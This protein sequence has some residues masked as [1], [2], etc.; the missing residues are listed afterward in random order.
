MKV[1]KPEVT[2]E[3]LENVY[4]GFLE[5]FSDLGA[6]PPVTVDAVV[7]EMREKGKS[8]VLRDRGVARNLLRGTKQGVWGTE[9]RSGVQ[10]Q[11]PVGVWG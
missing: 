9:A 4:E 6:M 5:V 11:S 10:G 7:R 2:V 3:S 1:T 8:T